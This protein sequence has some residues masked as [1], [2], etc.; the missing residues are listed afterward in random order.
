[1]VPLGTAVK[2]DSVGTWRV[3]I[4]MVEKDNPD[5]SNSVL[6]V[7]FRGE[8]TASVRS[9]SK[10]GTALSTVQDQITVAN[11]NEAEEVDVIDAK[12]SATIL[13]ETDTL[14]IILEE[15]KK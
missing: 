2:Q 10:D 9:P 8:V 7:F 4:P 15:V 13:R 12:G 14:R 3:A 1:M 6:E 5:G 11:P